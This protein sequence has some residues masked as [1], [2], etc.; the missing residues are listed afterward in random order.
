[1]VTVSR[2]SHLAPQTIGRGNR[3]SFHRIGRSLMFVM[4]VYGELLPFRFTLGHGRFL[5]EM[6]LN[7]LS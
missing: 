7:V 4:Q 3:A 2:H 6:V 1:M 5:K